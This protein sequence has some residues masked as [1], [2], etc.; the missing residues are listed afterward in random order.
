M[1]VFQ[2]LKEAGTKRG[3]TSLEPK[4]DLAI[5]VDI[6]MCTLAGMWEGKT[7]IGSTGKYLVRV[8]V[9]LQMVYQNTDSGGN[10]WD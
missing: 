7:T 10:L 3:K 6:R 8:I 2:H 9:N 4:V 1:T 5:E